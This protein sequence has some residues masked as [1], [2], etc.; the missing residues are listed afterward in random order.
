MRLAGDT[1]FMGSLIDPRVI[2][3]RCSQ[4]S[5]E[6]GD[7]HH[8]DQIGRLHQEEDDECNHCEH[9]EEK[10]VFVSYK[11]IIYEVPA[12]DVDDDI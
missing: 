8:G 1:I 6:P 7:L 11:V 5:G 4:L 3:I 2:F 12:R 9:L 10:A